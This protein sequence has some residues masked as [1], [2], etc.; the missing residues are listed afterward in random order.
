MKT[1]ILASII[2]ASILASSAAQA[3]SVAE[4]KSANDKAKTY[5]A[6]AEEIQK[7]YA[8]YGTDVTREALIRLSA[9]YYPG[10]AAQQ[11]KIAQKQN[12][13]ENAY[14]VAAEEIQKQYAAYGT[15]VTREALIRLSAHYYPDLSKPRTQTAKSSHTTPSQM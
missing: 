3:G 7:Q 6:A 14:L 8:A 11:N 9:Y 10:F 5:L 1:R 2:T 12:D 4:T 13:T 15:D